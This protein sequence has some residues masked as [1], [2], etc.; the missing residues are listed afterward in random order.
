M[1][2]KRVDS[3]SESVFWLALQKYAICLMLAVAQCAEFVG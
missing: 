1:P 3:A 2:R